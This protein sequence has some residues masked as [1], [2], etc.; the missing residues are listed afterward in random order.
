MLVASIA[1]LLLAK[2][3]FYGLFDIASHLIGPKLNAGDF[4]AP[5]L[6]WFRLSDPNYW[7]PSLESLHHGGWT[8]DATD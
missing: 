2:M 1:H 5:I 7:L 8:H 6:F 4:S 3:N